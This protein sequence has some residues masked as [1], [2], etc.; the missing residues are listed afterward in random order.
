VTARRSTSTRPRRKAP[1]PRLG[2]LD[3]G[4]VQAAILALYSHRDIGSFR[5]AAPEIFLR[6]I[7]ADLFSLLDIRIDSRRRT[8][9]MLDLWESR[10]GNIG[11]NSPDLERTLYDHPFTKHFEKHGSLDHAMKLSDFMTLSQLRRTPLYKL[12]LQPLNVE[13]ILSIGSNSGPGLATLTVTRPATQPDFSERDRRV[14]EVLRPHFDQARANLERETLMRANRSRS[15][16]ASG[17]T[18]RETEV[19]LWLAQGKTNPEIAII[20]VAPARTIEKHVEHILRKLGVEN[21]VAAAV[22]VTE[23]IGA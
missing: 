15:L 19:A 7:P 12:G 22:E 9:Q 1:A 5:R 10:P 21:R 20:L 13:H 17:L 2:A 4:A 18:P 14:L 11:A 8:V 23:I 6:L 16:R 3:F